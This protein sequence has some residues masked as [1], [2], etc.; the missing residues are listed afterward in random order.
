MQ[1]KK[2]LGQPEHLSFIEVKFDN[3]VE[4]LVPIPYTIPLT[5]TKCSLSF[6]SSTLQQQYYSTGQKSPRLFFGQVDQIDN[7]LALWYFNDR[8]FKLSKRIALKT[9]FTQIL[10]NRGTLNF[11]GKETIEVYQNYNFGGV[12]LINLYQKHT[13][14]YQF[15]FLQKKQ[16]HC[17]CFEIQ[18]IFAS[19][20]Y[21]KLKPLQFVDYRT[22]LDI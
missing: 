10:L 22:Y 17:C 5:I 12:V 13:V 14:P 1:K 21:I 3:A 8:K 18:S 19:I 2:S 11:A 20:K 9:H 16:K 4:S 6:V 7:S 15:N